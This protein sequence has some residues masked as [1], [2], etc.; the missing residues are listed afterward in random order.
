MIS[1]TTILA[2]ILLLA[3]VYMCYTYPQNIPLGIVLVVL[4]LGY[5][6]LAK[7]FNEPCSPWPRK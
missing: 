4:I 1:R 6:W 5:W 7:K 2:L 3:V